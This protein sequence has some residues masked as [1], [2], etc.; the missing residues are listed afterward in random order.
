[1]LTFLTFS[2]LKA[3]GT[4]SGVYMPNLKEFEPIM[5]AEE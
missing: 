3:S 5:N 1:M 2:N 4:S